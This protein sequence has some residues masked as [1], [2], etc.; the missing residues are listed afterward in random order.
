VKNNSYLVASCFLLLISVFSSGCTRVQ[1]GNQL[2]LA[3][4][5]AP[6]YHPVGVGY[7]GD[8]LR[9]GKIE[10]SG[11]LI[12]Q[13]K[14]RVADLVSGRAKAPTPE[15]YKREMSNLAHGWFFGPGFGTA[16]FNIGTAIAVPPYAFY[17]LGNAALEVSGLGAVYPTD[18][19]PDPAANVVGGAFQQVVSVPGRLNS[20]IFDEPFN[21]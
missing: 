18:L 13:S 20:A 6:A 5:Q 19:L 16:I 17:L 15:E 21:E 14:Q 12:T 3:L 11:S 9:V 2:D 1:T 7:L 10:P 4:E 8:P